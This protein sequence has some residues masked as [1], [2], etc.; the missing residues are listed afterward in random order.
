MCRPPIWVHNICAIYH[1]IG[2]FGVIIG[3]DRIR[4]SE[5]PEVLIYPAGIERAPVKEGIGPETAGVGKS[6]RAFHLCACACE[7]ES[8]TVQVRP[9]DRSHRGLVLLGMGDLAPAGTIWV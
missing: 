9:E 1:L 3:R 4:E 7:T 2:N 8:S 5:T 6:P